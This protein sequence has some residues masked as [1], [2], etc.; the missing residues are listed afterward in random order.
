MKQLLEN[1]NAELVEQKEIMEEWNE[2]Y[3]EIRK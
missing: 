2:Y 1:I 3:K